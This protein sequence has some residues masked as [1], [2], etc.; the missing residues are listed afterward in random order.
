MERPARVLGEP[1]AHVGMLVGGVIVGDGV[2]Q[3]AGRH[4]GLDLRM[5]S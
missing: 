1:S 5:N 2:D 3:L 4:S